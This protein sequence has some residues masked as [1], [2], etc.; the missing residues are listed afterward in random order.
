MMRRET[1]K[2]F[3]CWDLASCCV[4]KPE[5]LW[6]Q[7]QTTL[8]GNGCLCFQPAYTPKLVAD[9]SCMKDVH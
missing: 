4:W 1:W 6:E 7:T 8:L 9:S 2:E 5:L 3:M